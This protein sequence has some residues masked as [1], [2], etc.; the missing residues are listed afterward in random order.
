MC[1]AGEET[2]TLE[3]TPFLSYQKSE[4]SFSATAT[5]GLSLCANGDVRVYLNGNKRMLFMRLMPS[6]NEI[7]IKKTIKT[8]V[9]NNAND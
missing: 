6:C 5:A 7:M 3:S 2:F 1:V 4:S 8:S 9:G